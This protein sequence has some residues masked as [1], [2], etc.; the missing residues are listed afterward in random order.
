MFSIS[1]VAS[2]GV[3]S[4]IFPPAE[5]SNSCLVCSLSLSINIF[6]WIGSKNPW[7]GVLLNKPLNLS[8]A[9]LRDSSGNWWNEEIAAFSFAILNSGKYFFRNFSTTSSQVVR[10]LP[11]NEWSH[12]LA[13]PANENEKRLSLIASPSTPTILT[14]LHISMNVASVTYFL[15]INSPVL[16]ELRNVDSWCC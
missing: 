4:F 10:L 2:S 15:E 14:V 7:V 6:N 13:S 11:L 12:L 5:A 9:S 8:N 1:S 3:F 16:N